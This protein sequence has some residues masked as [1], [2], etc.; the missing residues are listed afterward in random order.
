[1]KLLFNSPNSPKV[2][3]RGLSLSLMLKSHY[4][5]LVFNY[6]VTLTPW[7]LAQYVFTLLEKESLCAQAFHS[8]FFT[9]FSLWR[10]R[11]WNFPRR[12]CRSNYV[13]HAIQQELRIH[14]TVNISSMIVLQSTDIIPCQQS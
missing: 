3:E 8:P 12:R 11:L 2:R 4:V 10:D 7:I 1:M 9:A 13:L 6:G 14:G 5:F